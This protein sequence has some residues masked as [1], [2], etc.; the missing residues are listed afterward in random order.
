MKILQLNFER[1]WR[2]GERQTLY[3]MRQF[4]QAGHEV[5][6]MARRGSQ[7]A[8]TARAEG[9][10][11]YEQDGPLGQI[12]F[13]M[14]SGKKFDIIHAQTANTITWAALTRWAHRRPVVFSRRTDFRVRNDAKIRIKWQR[15]DLFVAISES[16]AAEPRRLGIKPVIIRSAVEPVT[17]DQARVQRFLDE[18]VPTGKRLISTSA[19]LINDKDPLTMIEAVN[20]LAQQRDDFVFVHLGGSGD[21]EQAARARV[22]ELGLEKIYLFAGFQKDIES[23]YSAMDVFAMS[24]V[25]EALGSSVLDAFLQRIPVVST[26]AGGLKESLADG[27][28]VLCKT[29]D[30]EAMAEGMRR[31]LDD[32]AFREAAIARA[33]DYVRQEHD[34][35][36]MARRY[37]REFEGLLQR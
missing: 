8:N 9:F 19:A 22:A 12:G 29:G 17:V 36:E 21:A 23:L 20:I 37:L 1:G 25:E 7:M 30:Y 6:L 28:G 14:G 34:V 24:S 27:R 11:V 3:C 10:H 32:T 16:A 13:L 31:M 26:D 35:Q 2:G 15:I 4:R 18:W 33:H 5:S